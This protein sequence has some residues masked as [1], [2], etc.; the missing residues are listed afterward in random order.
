M[1][2]RKGLHYMYILKKAEKIKRKIEYALRG[3]K[4]PH[5]SRDFDVSEYPRDLALG[6]TRKCNLNCKM[7]GKKYINETQQDEMTLE[8]VKTI[9]EKIPNINQINFVDYGE[10]LMAREIYDI[11]EYLEQNNIKTIITTN[12]LL[13]NEENINKLK[14]VFCVYIS[15][16]SVDDETHK[17]IRGIDFTR[18]KENLKLL[19]N[20]RP[21]IQIVTQT[22]LMEENISQLKDIIDFAAEVGAHHVSFLKKFSGTKELDDTNPIY[23]ED[24][25]KKI[26]EAYK[27]LKKKKLSINLHKYKNPFFLVNSCM[28]PFY[29]LR[30]NIDGTVFA[31][32]YIQS[33]HEEYF[34]GKKTKNPQS[35]FI[36][37]NIFTDDIRNIW[38]GEQINK[39]RNR[40]KNAKKDEERISIEEFTKRRKE[41]YT[42]GD[43]CE[44]CDVCLYR[45]KSAF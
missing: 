15:I 18:I 28:E 3:E 16:D 21:N 39:I 14:S 27:Y 32:T 44:Y 5:I 9:V 1:G 22:V 35:Q 30:I 6:I 36:L 33:Y 34:N 45:W 40:I 38:H 37:G 8:K 7:C 17:K 2:D 20:L 31:C 41:D 10:T 43:G 42:S 13:L 29:K 24:F 19:K 11:L 23:K 25:E 12:G 4:M 26:K